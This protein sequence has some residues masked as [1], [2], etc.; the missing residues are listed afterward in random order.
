M[1]TYYLIALACL[2]LVIALA[3]LAYANTRQ[4]DSAPACHSEDV[5]AMIENSL[6]S[7]WPYADKPSMANANVRVLSMRPARVEGKENV[8]VVDY[9]I[10]GEAPETR[11][12]SLAHDGCSWDVAQMTL[13]YESQKWCLDS[14]CRGFLET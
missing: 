5:R 7:S 3:C 8:C 1:E 13:P 2:M 6:A 9:S 11:M 14:R 4:C 12:Y 10:D